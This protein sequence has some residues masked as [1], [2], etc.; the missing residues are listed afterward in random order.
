MNSGGD[1]D[2]GPG[3]RRSP[4]TRGLFAVRRRSA[5]EV[6]PEWS[7]VGHNEESVSEGDSEPLTAEVSSELISPIS[8]NP[9]DRE[10]TP[11][12]APF[13]D[14]PSA[15]VLDYVEAFDGQLVIRAASLR[16]GIHEET[17]EPRQDAYQLAVD[18]NSI[19]IAVCDGVGSQPRSH[20]GAAVAAAAC[21]ASSRRGASRDDIVRDVCS[22]LIEQANLLNVTPVEVSTTLCWARI[23][24]GESGG[25]WNVEIAEWG[26]SEALLYERSV[27]TTDGHPDW[28]RLP[29]AR[30][31]G[32]VNDV[33]ALPEAVDL[34]ASLTGPW[35][36][37]Q[38]LALCTDGIASDV[39]PNTT[40]GHA[41]AQAWHQPP[42]RW[43]FASQIAYRNRGSNDDRTAVVLWRLD[44]STVSEDGIGEVSSGL[45]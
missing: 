37:S 23:T 4:R 27:P 26:D 9:P 38:V 25:L 40:V 45:A 39:A 7:D 16:G 32:L 33:R 43:E 15:F 21:V 10:R 18:N 14:A 2:R 35:E 17:A 34:C 13:S 20:M 41:L 19:H 1:T 6:V 29:K 42:S 11:A 28:R 36:P 31:D 22:A 24:V 3:W 30:S 5:H 8:V 12:W 44:G